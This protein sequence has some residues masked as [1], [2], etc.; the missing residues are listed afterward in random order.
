MIVLLQRVQTA[1][2]EVEKEIIGEI[3]QGLLAF[4]GFEDSDHPGI[5]D[6]MLDKVLHYRIFADADG[7]MNWNV[8]QIGG[9]VLLVPQ[10]TLAADTQRGLR[11]SFSSAAKPAIAK[12]LFEVTV[13]AMQ[14]RYAQVAV[15]QFGADMQVHLIND[16]PVTFW[17]QVRG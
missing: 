1:K 8:Q 13:E 10:F 17:L 2:V 14:Q 6:K 15:G 11:P 16:G 3:A 7:R 5:I 4:V 9:G 12:M